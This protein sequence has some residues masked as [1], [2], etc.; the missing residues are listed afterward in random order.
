[1]NL[2]GGDLLVRLVLF[3]AVFMPWGAKWSMDSFLRRD[4][5]AKKKEAHNSSEKSHTWTAS[6]LWESKSSYLLSAA[7]LGILVQF[8]SMYLFSYGLKVRWCR[9]WPAY[10]D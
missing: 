5:R 10:D 4:D 9:G 1:M 8:A 3:W 6:E 2:N 7:T